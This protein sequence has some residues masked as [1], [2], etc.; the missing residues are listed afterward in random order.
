MSIEEFAAYV[1]LLPEGA[2]AMYGVRIIGFIDAEGTTI[3]DWAVDGDVRLGE[4]IGALVVAQHQMIH[5][6]SDDDD[7]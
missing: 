6:V 4:A 5:S 2:V 3:H 1:D 7:E